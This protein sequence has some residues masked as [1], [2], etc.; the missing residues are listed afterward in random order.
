MDN[1]LNQNT[2]REH[3]QKLL[4]E[5]DQAYALI[6]QYENL[7]AKLRAEND[8]NLQ[9]ITHDLSNPLQIL[10]MTI[11]SFQDSPPKDIQATLVRMKRSTDM[12]TEIISA[13]RKLRASTKEQTTIVV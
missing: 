8:G 9:R 7:I 2:S 13:I 11:E 5:L 12:M 1:L 4:K 6:A 10:A 3:N